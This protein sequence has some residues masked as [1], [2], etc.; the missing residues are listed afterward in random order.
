M[1]QRM[2]TMLRTKLLFGS[3]LSVPTSETRQPCQLPDPVRHSPCLL[4]RA[5]LR[6]RI[7]CS[8]VALINTL[9]HSSG[10]RKD[11]HKG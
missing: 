6:D 11:A 2:Y 8:R 4:I 5:R 3:P 7:S 10:L 1:L 9:D